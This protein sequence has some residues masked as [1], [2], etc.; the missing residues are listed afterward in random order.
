M[1][2]RRKLF[3]AMSSFIVAMGLMFILLTQ[4]VVVPII[5]T[6]LEVDRTEETEALADLFSDY[7][8]QNG[9]AWDGV[10]HL[11]VEDAVQHN[12]REMNILLIDRH[13]QTL[14]AEGNTENDIVTKLGIHHQI[15]DGEQTIA[16]MYYYDSD[17]A[18]MSIVQQGI[19]SS[20]MALLFFASLFF[21]LI[22]L[23]VAYWLSKRL[24][25]P[26]KLMIPPIERLAKGDYGVQAPI[27]SQ[28]EYA[29]VTK[30]FNEMSEQ[31]KNAED[32]RRQMTADVAHE[33]RTPLTILSGKLDYIQQR[34]EAIQP[35][36]LLPLQDELIRLTRLVEDLRL[37][38]LAEAKKLPMKRMPIDLGDLLH[39]LI[40]KLQPKADEKGI[41]I[42]V[43]SQVDN[44]ELNIDPNRMTQVFLN[45][46]INAIHFTPVGGSV[47]VAIMKEKKVSN[48][49]M[50]VVTIRDTGVGI[51]PEHLPHLFNRFYRTDQ[52]RGRDSGGTGLGLAI[53]KEYVRSHGG[54]ITVES[55]PNEGT[56]FIVS[57]PL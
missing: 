34:G 13:Q 44:T 41:D 10:N 19:S 31:L 22:S 12:H 37:L 18:S 38:S 6:M 17:V 43:S 47:D 5:D 20:V 9:H 8:I 36:S 53:A 24:T 51:E 27:V 40:D 56:S 1:S 11:Q 39:E 42:T 50:I 26:L 45:L 21:V 48:E 57:L 15:T 2:V 4:F 29:T 16:T 3:L 7:Y 30:S 52:A 55:T 54:T 46:F 14:F 32:T 23:M 33:L 28:D 49:D 35:E 25:T